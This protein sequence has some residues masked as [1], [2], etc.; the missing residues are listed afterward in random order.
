MPG[1]EMPKYRCHKVVHA[2]KIERLEVPD[3][4]SLGLLVVPADE[5][6]APFHVDVEWVG[7]HTPE[8][9]GYYVVY[10]D[11]YTSFSPGVP[12]ENGYTRL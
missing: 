5:G 1:Q 10:E 3:D 12:F 6:F 11:G 4:P 2:L 8:A 7:R 9:G